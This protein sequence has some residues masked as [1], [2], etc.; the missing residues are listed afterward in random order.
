MRIYL[1]AEHL[2][3]SQE[4]QLSIEKITEGNIS[5]TAHIYEKRVLGL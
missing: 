4:G 2:L 5:G 1:L 3:A